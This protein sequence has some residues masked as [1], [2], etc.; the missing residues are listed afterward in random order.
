M[1]M[2]SASFIEATVETYLPV[3]RCS[4]ERPRCSAQAPWQSVGV[5]SL[6]PMSL[7]LPHVTKHFR[8]PIVSARAFRSDYK[9]IVTSVLANYQVE[10]VT[11]QANDPVNHRIFERD[12]SHMPLVAEVGKPGNDLSG[13]P[14]TGRMSMGFCAMWPRWSSFDLLSAVGLV[15][16][17]C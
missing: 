6:S 4:A 5:H 12:D 7:P 15:L 2:S 17:V 11:F 10:R 1:P 13:S 8:N 3:A 14:P 16:L 9:P